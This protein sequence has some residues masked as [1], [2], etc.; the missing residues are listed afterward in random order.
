MMKVIDEQYFF[1]C[2]L[3]SRFKIDYL[4]HTGGLMFLP[5]F[6]GG[7]TLGMTAC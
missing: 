7:T 2:D 5:L 6:K 1:C 3:V 4:R